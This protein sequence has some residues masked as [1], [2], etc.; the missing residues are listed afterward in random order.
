MRITTVLIFKFK[1]RFFFCFFFS[2]AFNWHLEYTI[3]LN[4]S[5]PLFRADASFLLFFHLIIAFDDAEWRG[6]FFIHF[7]ENERVK[8]KNK[9]ESI[10]EYNFINYIMDIIMHFIIVF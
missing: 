1:E 10:H 7:Y 8:K 9:D 5:A 6:F 3:K 4:I 2:F